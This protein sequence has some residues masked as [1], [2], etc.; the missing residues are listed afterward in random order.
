MR[1]L[2]AF[3]FVFA[4]GL[5]ALSDTPAGFGLRAVVYMPLHYAGL[6][7]ASARVAYF[8]PL[9]IASPPRP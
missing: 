4:F 3:I 1:Y 7:T 2:H 6:D 9:R 5:I 8:A